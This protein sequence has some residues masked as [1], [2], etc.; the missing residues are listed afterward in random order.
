MKT[1][2]LVCFLKKAEKDILIFAQLKLLK[3][4]F[5]IVPNG[6]NST[7]AKPFIS[8]SL[9]SSSFVILKHYQYTDK[10][11]K[12]ISKMQTMRTGVGKL[13]LPKVK[14]KIF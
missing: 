13:S 1:S 6:C 3:R 14:T 4:Y 5:I 8:S 12:K 7:K 11:I 2:S 10:L 9:K